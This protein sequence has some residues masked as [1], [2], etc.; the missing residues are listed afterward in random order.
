M[1]IEKIKDL[2]RSNNFDEL[3]KLIDDINI[4]DFINSIKTKGKDEFKHDL[5]ELLSKH[6]FTIEEQN[7]RIE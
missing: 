3:S 7:K 4:D 6:R 2:L 5:K 1:V